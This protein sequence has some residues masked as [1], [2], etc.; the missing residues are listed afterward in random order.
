[1]KGTEMKGRKSIPTKLKI[2]AGNPGK[3]KADIEHNE[4]I[5]PPGIPTIPEWLQS[6]PVAAE[7]WDRESEILLAMDLFSLAEAGTFAMR[8]YLASQIQEVAG[9]LEGVED[10]KSYNQIKQLITEYRNIGSLLGLDPASRTKL[11]VDPSKKVKSKFAGL[12][13]VK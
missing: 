9:K 5:P 7:E 12:V 13:S 2:L 1:M 4:P 6:F 11:S 10:D 3:R 8:C